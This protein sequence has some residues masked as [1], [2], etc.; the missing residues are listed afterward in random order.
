[1]L[2]EQRAQWAI[3]FEWS[4]LQA[5]LKNEGIHK[6]S[7]QIKNHFSDLGKKLRAWEFL[8]RRTGVGVDPTTGAIVMR[9]D[10]WDVFLQLRHC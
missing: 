2:I 7:A 6:D 9:D 5:L 8:I 3:K 4:L 10:V 1:L